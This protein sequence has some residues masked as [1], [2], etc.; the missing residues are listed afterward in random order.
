MNYGIGVG[1]KSI[2]GG[3]NVI[4]IACGDL[5]CKHEY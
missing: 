4:Y 2:L 1:S 3:P 5:R